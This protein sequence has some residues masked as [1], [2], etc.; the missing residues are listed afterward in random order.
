V[1]CYLSILE[2]LPIQQDFITRRKL[3]TLSE[4][5]LAEVLPEGLEGIRRRLEGTGGGWLTQHPSPHC[6]HSY[7]FANSF[8]AHPPALVP[9][10][11]GY[12]AS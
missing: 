5:A 3:V 10:L 1:N 11:S 9:L 12:S 4:R 2:E 6:V 8:S 7:V